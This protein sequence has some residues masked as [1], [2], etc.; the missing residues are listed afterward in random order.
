MEEELKWYKRRWVSLGFLSFSLLVIALDNTVLNLALPSI[1]KELGSD[2]T[3]LQWI[4]DAYVVVFAGLLLTM[5]SLGDKFGRKKF[6]QSGLIVFRCF[7]LGAA[8]SRSTNMLIAMRAVM[9]IGAAAI[10]PSTLS[11]LTATFR[12]ARERAQAIALWTAVFALGW[13]IGPLVGGWLLTISTGVLFF[14]LIS[15][16]WP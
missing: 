14:I 16:S 13:G 8:L 12:N 15:P 4:V 9:G 5:G 2:G 11:I 1:S 7:S 10:M 3:E 6:L